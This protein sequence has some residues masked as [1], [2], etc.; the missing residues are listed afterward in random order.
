MIVVFV[1]GVGVLAL[2]VVEAVGKGGGRG[3]RG[4]RMQ[5][6]RHGMTVVKM[7]LM[8]VQW[9]CDSIIKMSHDDADGDDECCCRK[10]SDADFAVSWSRLAV[11]AQSELP[12][13]STL[14]SH[15]VIYLSASLA[16]DD[17]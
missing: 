13:G 15:S 17:K 14:G 7:T 9:W 1:G 2:S 8:T 6:C 5:R 4:L 12:P 16:R 11:N 3:G 10:V